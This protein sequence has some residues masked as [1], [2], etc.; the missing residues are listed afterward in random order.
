MEIG[1]GDVDFIK[2]F[3]I[4]DKH[5]PDV[6]YIPEVWQGHKNGGEGFWQ[7]LEFL[8]RLLVNDRM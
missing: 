4:L 5:N 2:L 7:A 6:Q 1:K 8:E 3:K